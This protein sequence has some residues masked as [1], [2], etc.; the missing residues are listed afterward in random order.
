MRL[1]SWNVNG[2]RDDYGRRSFER[3]HTTLSAMGLD[4]IALQEVKNPEL[5][6]TLGR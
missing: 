3:V 2:W 5:V 1:C 6:A 4:L